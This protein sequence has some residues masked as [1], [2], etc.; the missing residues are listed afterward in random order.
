M[1]ADDHGLRSSEPFDPADTRRVDSVG[2]Q[3]P[4]DEVGERVVADAAD[5]GGLEA[6]TNEID[7]RVRSAPTRLDEEVLHGDELAGLRQPV[8]WREE[9]VRDED[10]EA[11]DTHGLLVYDDR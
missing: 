6:E 1:D 11:D 9:H 4:D 3:L 2:G 8:Q 10:P 7:R 5:D